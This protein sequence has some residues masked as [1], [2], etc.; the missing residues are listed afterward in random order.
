MDFKR[1]PVANSFG[2]FRKTHKN[3]LKTANTTVTNRAIATTNATLHG[4]NII[5][6]TNK[7]VQEAQQQKYQGPNKI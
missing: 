7:H 1:L 4:S 6:M 5:L 2:T 3:T